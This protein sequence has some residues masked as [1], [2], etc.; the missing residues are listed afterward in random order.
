MAN[1]GKRPGRTQAQPHRSA[2]RQA[3][4]SQAFTPE[5]ADPTLAD[6]V[7]KRDLKYIESGR[8]PIWANMSRLRFLAFVV[9]LPL[10]ILAGFGLYAPEV[11][12]DIRY[13][14]T[15]V[16]AHD[17]RATDGKCNRYAFLVTL[18][19]SKL[20]SDR[21]GEMERT[22]SFMMFFR[23]GDGAQMIPVRS[24]ANASAV[25]ISYAVNDVLLNRTLSL[26]GGT[27]FFGWI[28]WLFLNCVRKGRYKGGPAHE[29]V[30]QHLALR[31]QPA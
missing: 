22:T 9:F 10:L 15:Y 6:L 24:T 19:S 7:S 3:A 20:R 21:R 25:G 16:P 30:L 8:L 18:C 31:A 26:L 11:V 17:L 14:G 2:P 23:S 13:A 12:R 27:A 29:A 5:A 1:F 28:W 4:P